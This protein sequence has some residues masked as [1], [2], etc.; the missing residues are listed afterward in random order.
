MI[1]EKNGSLRYGDSRHERQDSTERDGQDVQRGFA[2]YEWSQIFCC[3]SR[4]GLKAK[5]C[6]EKDS[7][8]SEEYVDE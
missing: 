6:E 2:L 5:G 7:H 3:S 1:S 4:L 8:E